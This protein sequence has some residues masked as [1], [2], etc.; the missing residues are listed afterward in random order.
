MIFELALWW[1]QELL[2][3]ATLIGSALFNGHD[4]FCISFILFNNAMLSRPLGF[5]QINYKKEDKIVMIYYCQQE[6][7]VDCIKIA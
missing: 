1:P 2:T 7:H 3:Q 6:Y 5:E 4:S